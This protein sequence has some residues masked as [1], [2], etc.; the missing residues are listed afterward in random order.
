MRQRL[1]A[2]V[3][4]GLL[5]S[6]SI[7]AS[8]QIRLDLVPAEATIVTSGSATLGIQVSGN[9]NQAVG[10]WSLGLQFDPS[11]VSFLSFAFGD[12]LGDDVINESFLSTDTLSLAAT[13]LESVADLEALQGDPVAL[14][15]VTFAGLAPG[16]SSIQFVNGTQ[17]GIL[18][19]DANGVPL[20][21]DL[22]GARITVAQ[23]AVPE[24]RTLLL[25]ALGLLVLLSTA[26]ARRVLRSTRRF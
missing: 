22:G 17:G 21:F 7:S 13:S 2:Q 9:G 25:F 18:L 19:V 16:V 11:I 14:A 10:A 6:L 12:A 20:T 1:V 4:F 23:S 24:P 3:L 8:A 26:R 5:L 15:T